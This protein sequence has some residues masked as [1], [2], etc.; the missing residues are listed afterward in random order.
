MKEKK[1]S[2]SLLLLFLEEDGKGQKYSLINCSNGQIRGG[3]SIDIS[4][5]N[6]LDPKLIRLLHLI[7]DH[8]DENYRNKPFIDGSVEVE[9][10]SEWEDGVEEKVQ[11]HHIHLQ[12]LG[13][14]RL[15]SQ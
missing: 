3:K 14:E 2:F 7:L 6:F 13:W 9:Q 1:S 4:A 15:N 8:Q 11:P 5:P 12:K 10:G